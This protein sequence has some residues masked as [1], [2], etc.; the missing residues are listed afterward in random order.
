MIIENLSKTYNGI[1]V[2][3]DL[4]FEIK[5]NML[6]SF[7]GPNGAGKST[8]LMLMAKLIKKDEGNIF[9]D[10][11]KIENYSQKEYAKKV[12]VL[13]QNNEANMRITVKDL[14]FFGRFPHSE[15][16][17]TLN[18]D[19]IVNKTID[20][21]GL[22]DIENKY[23]TEISGGQRQRAYIAMCLAQDTKYILLDEPT[24]NLDIFYCSSTMKLL[25]KLCLDSKKTII[26]VLHDINYASFYS[27]YIYAFLNGKIVN[28]GKAE[29]II[30]KDNLKKIYNTDFEIQYFNGKPLSIYY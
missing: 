13:T 8:A 15:N 25:K 23:I 27:D 14:I 4:N 24:N 22:N 6:T 30:T 10:S 28:H 29:K 20:Y 9:V 7:I 16:R 5:E 1:K 2:L 17:F 21:M 12:S 18:D 3:D 19:M 11:K 26:T